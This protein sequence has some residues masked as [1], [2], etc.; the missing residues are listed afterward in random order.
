M[1]KAFACSYWVT[2]DTLHQLDA[3]SSVLY[4]LAEGGSADKARSAMDFGLGLLNAGGI[5][6]NVETAGVAHN[7]AD[8]KGM[9]E[10]KTPWD[11]MR[12]RRGVASG[13]ETT[14]SCGMH[15]FGLRDVLWT[16]ELPKDEAARLVN[17]FALYEL[18]E[19]P[20][21]NDGETFSLTADSPRYR[22]RAESCT[23][24]PPSDTFYNPY[25][26]WRLADLEE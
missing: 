1:R 5:G 26:M 8:W 17:R 6:V 24:F 10:T 13:D 15:N 12:V 18:A 23:M 4:L 21:L 25:G 22:L 19:E 2:E 3:H 7:P 9:S 16:G 14:Y 20:T 11:L